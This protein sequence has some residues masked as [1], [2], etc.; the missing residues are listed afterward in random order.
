[1]KCIH[2]IG[3]RFGVHMCHM[4]NTIMTVQMMVMIMQ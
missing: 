3:S 1:M 2:P 4:C